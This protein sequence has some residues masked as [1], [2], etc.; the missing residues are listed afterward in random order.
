MR[1]QSFG[2]VSFATCDATGL[3]LFEEAVFTGIQAAERCL[4]LLDLPY[5]TSVRGLRHD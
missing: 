5:A 2:P 4:D 3:P 1:R